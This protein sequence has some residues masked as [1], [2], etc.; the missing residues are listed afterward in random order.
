MKRLLTIFTLTVFLAIL[1]GTASADTFISGSDFNNPALVGSV[2]GTYVA[3]PSGHMHL[4]Y[5]DGT[6]AVVGAKGP[7][8]TLTGLSMSF[9]YSNMSPGTSSPYAA[10]GLSE[11]SLWDMSAQEFQVMAMSGAQI[12]DSTLV[13]VVNTNTGANYIPMDQAITLGQL[14]GES[15]NGFAF[16]DMNVL[17]AYAYIGNW[18]G[19]T[20]ASVDIN[21]ITVTSSVPEP[22]SMLLLGLGLVGLAGIRRKLK[23]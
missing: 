10:F 6:Q 1:T 22:A 20:N 18:P 12:N 7:F 5:G 15:Y 9:D 17:R 19:V 8:G 14:L 23:S 13:H 2:N 21:S 3:A 11:N 4:A 16:G